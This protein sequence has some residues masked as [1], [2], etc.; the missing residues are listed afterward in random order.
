MEMD[1]T[2]II[3]VTTEF[4]VKIASSLDIFE[5]GEEI[6]DSTMVAFSNMKLFSNTKDSHLKLKLPELTATV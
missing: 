5:L 1:K 6:S 2:D 3:F 4:E